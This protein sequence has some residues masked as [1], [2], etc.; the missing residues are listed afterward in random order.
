MFHVHIHQEIWEDIREPVKVLIGGFVILVLI[1]LEIWAVIELT[2]LLFSNRHISI[3]I[4]IYISD[5]AAIIFSIRYT[6]WP[7]LQRN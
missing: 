6:V 1:L 2:E 5:I 7:L 3:I 4:L